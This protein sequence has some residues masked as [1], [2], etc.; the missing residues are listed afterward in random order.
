MT[1]KKILLLST[2]GTIASVA[3]EEGLIPGRSGAELLHTLGGLPYEVEVK[4]I[5]SLDSSN[6]QPEEWAFI[7]EQIYKLRRGFDGIVV[8]HG[9]DTM[10]YTA[11]MLTFMLQGIDLPVV[12]TGSQ[13]PMQAILSDAPDNLRVAFAAA[14]TCKPGIYIAFNRQIMRGCRCVKIRTTGFDA[15]KS[16]NVD[17]VAMVTSDGIDIK[18]KDFEYVPSEHAICTLN[19]KVEPQVA[20]IKL[21]PG[22]DPAVL[23]AMVDSGVKGIVIEA[24]GLGGMNYMRRN[25]VKAI[26]KIIKRGV[27]VVACSQ[28]LYERTDL[29]KYEVGRAAMLEGAIS[30]RDMTSESAV[31]KLMWALGQ[32]MDLEDVRA[33]F[34]KDIAGEVTITD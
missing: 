2:G 30:G 34:N 1:N 27:P 23:S 33:F 21:F 31:T 9:T 17:P 28:C 4:D 10:A 25:M 6:I 7:A 22:F 5:L 24:Y 8:S 14:A 15:F 11:S 16:I 12:L 32:G 20:M 3:S 26:G 19:T 29:T 18:H 13:A